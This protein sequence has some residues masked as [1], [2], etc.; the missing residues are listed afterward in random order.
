MSTYRNQYFA[1]GNA[2]KRRTSFNFMCPEIQFELMTIAV[3]DWSLCL[4]GDWLCPKDST[5]VFR[6]ILVF[7]LILLS[8]VGEFIHTLSYNIHFFLWNR[9]FSGGVFLGPF[10]QW[11]SFLATTKKIVI[12]IIRFVFLK[13]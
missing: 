1:V 8:Y 5:A 11:R 9:L 13:L 2:S 4:K 7:V 6:V 12:T 3:K 10:I